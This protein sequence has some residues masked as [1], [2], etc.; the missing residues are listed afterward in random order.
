M[1]LYARLRAGVAA[2]IARI[3]PVFVVGD[4]IRNSLFDIGSSGRSSD[5]RKPAPNERRGYALVPLVGVEPT[6]Y[7]YRGILSPVR[8]P[9]PPQRQFGS[10][11][12]QREFFCKHLIE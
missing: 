6:R 10:I 7:R 1:R 11:I 5:K 4:F 12:A 9:I 3:I 2:D 8:L